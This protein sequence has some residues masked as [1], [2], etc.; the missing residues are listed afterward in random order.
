M[1]NINVMNV[2]IH[3]LRVLYEVSRCSSVTKAASTLNMTQPAVSNLI[4]ALE[5]QVD[6]P[7]IEVLHKKLYITEVGQKLIAAY[8]VI[9]AQLQEVNTEINLL[10]GR[11]VGTIRIATVTTAKYFVPRLL[12]NFKS[13][14]PGVHVELKVK[15]R[16]EIVE[17]LQMNL[18]DFVIMSQ[19]PNNLSIEHHDF[20]EDELVVAASHLHPQKVDTKTT[21][22]LL[23]DEPWLIRELGSGTRMVMENIFKKYRLKPNI[24][25][26]IDNNESIKQ[27]IIANMGISMLSHQ[28]IQIEQKIGLIKVLDV[29]GFPVRHKWHLVKS[30][31][32]KLP[33]IA[34]KFY[35]Y[36]RT[37]PNLEVFSS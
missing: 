4:R 1:Y 21:L 14:Y 16:H 30:K 25:M 22:K 13:H 20:F 3:Q 28:S 36:V 32:K 12:G 37:H 10:K 6:A 23:A 8:E 5:L 27:A 11:M 33:I 26:E 24:E 19:P 7:V 34:Q 18:D 31:G 35:D 17:R 2:T 9:N 15:N 29:A